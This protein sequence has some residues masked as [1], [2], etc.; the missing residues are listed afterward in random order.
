MPDE[1]QDG[2][3]L[4]E[5]LAALDEGPVALGAGALLPAGVLPAPPVAGAM[6]AEA[7]ALGPTPGRALAWPGGGT[8][9]P[10][11]SG[12]LLG[13][14]GGAPVVE[15][16]TCTAPAFGCCA[17]TGGTPPLIDDAVTRM[18]G[19]LAASGTLL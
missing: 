1:S 6:A 3:G 14:T 7:A 18:L 4:V 12:T 11:G 5:T 15:G 9:S 19:S 16:W 8:L 10:G 17:V 2:A 13:A